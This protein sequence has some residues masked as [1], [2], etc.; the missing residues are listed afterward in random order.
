MISGVALAATNSS[1]AKRN[2]PVAQQRDE[3]R[4]SGFEQRVVEFAEQLGWMVGT[5][6]AK[7]HKWLD[8]AQ[9]TNKLTGI[10]DGALELLNHIHANAPSALSPN[11]SESPTGSLKSPRIRVPVDPVHA[12]GKRH[13]KPQP[14]VHGIKHSDARI[15][16]RKA[17]IENRG[18]PRQRG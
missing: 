13:R 3:S 6:E 9:L 18:R 14:A 1:M 10:R 12:P 7:T 5:A 11:E 8:P 2:R 16:K 4:A 17:V 15:A